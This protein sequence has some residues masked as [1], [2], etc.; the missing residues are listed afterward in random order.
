VLLPVGNH[1]VHQCWTSSSTVITAICRLNILMVLLTC[2][3][4]EKM[5]IPK[6][7]DCSILLNALT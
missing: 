1:S 7:T 2:R 5:V 4:K 3:W 6:Q